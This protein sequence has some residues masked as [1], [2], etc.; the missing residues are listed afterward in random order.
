MVVL[1]SIHSVLG[2]NR[3]TPRAPATRSGCRLGVAR[4]SSWRSACCGGIEDVMSARFDLG[5]VILREDAAIVLARAGQDADFFLAKHAADD[6]GEEDP[7][8]HEQ[9]LKE[10]SMGQPRPH[11]ARSRTAGRK[12][13]AGN[14]SLLPTAPYVGSTGTASPA[15]SRLG[16]WS[17]ANGCGLRNGQARIELSRATDGADSC[18]RT[19]G[20]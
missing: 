20:C 15:G 2:W 12:L 9:G 1:S 16:T 18:Q 8:R 14:V 3:I 13:H 5:K 4:R 19:G 10:G 11:P 7:T 6:W 17:A